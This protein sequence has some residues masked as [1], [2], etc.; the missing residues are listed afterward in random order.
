MVD[1]SYFFCDNCENVIAPKSGISQSKF[2]I[3]FCFWW[4]LNSAPWEHVK[5]KI[6][7]FYRIAHFCSYQ[8]QHS[9][10]PNN[11]LYYV[12]TVIVGVV[13]EYQKRVISG[14]VGL[15]LANEF[16]CPFFEIDLESGENIEECYATLASMALPLI[17]E[18]FKSIPFVYNKDIE[19]SVNDDKQNNNKCIIS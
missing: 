1:S 10:Q 3:Q 5:I 4:L 19:C 9:F 14:D 17:K 13:S 7:K 15:Q 2:Q 16:S 8:C 18:N 11:F 6:P 12:P